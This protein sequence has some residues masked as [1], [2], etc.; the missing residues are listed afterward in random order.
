MVDIVDKKKRSEMMSGIRSKNTKPELAIR[1]G[2]H[3]RGYRY[4]LHYKKLP[5]KPDIVMP[6]RKIVVLINGC[7]MVCFKEAIASSLS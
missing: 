4:R 6:G 3:A 5:G 2:L 7:F 1:K